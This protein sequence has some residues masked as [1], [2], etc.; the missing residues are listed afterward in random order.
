MMGFLEKYSRREQILLLIAGGLAL[1]LVL[2]LVVI[3]PILNMRSN[4]LADLASAQETYRL[5]ERAAKNGGSTDQLNPDQVG[6]IVRRSAQQAGF[7]LSTFGVSDN[8][9]YL[10]KLNDVSTK[11][12]FAWVYGLERDQKI[13]VAEGDIRKD[14]RSGAI[15]ATLFFVKK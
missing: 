1:F 4:N 8:N 3:N 10:V 11:D 5:V 7:Q 15:N 6:V 2:L 14:A 12:L 9:R 13:V